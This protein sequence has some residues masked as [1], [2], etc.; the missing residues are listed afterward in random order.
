M[1]NDSILNSEI[2]A[3]LGD[4]LA[5]IERDFKITLLNT[6]KDKIEINFEPRGVGK[7]GKM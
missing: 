4:I 6:K 2:I 7:N 1:K 3:R 5:L